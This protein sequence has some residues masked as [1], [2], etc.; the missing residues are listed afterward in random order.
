MAICDGHGLPLALHLASASPAEVRLVEDTLE[1]RFL[2]HYPDRLIGDKA[3]DSDA[4]DETLR[5][6]WGIE[7]I[8]RH[9]RNRKVPTQDGRP[10][11]RRKRRWKI[12]RLFAW[13]HNSRRLV[14]R[15]ERHPENFLAMFHLAAVIILLRHL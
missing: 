7:M 4:L 9:R 12:E 15:W 2:A 3:Y 1:D 13:F 10:L 11:R 6:T 5:T 8:A 14:V